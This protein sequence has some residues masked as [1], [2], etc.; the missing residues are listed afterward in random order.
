MANPQSR[1]RRVVR[2][3]VNGDHA[4]GDIL[5]QAPL[6]T[7]RRALPD[8]VGIEQQR[9]HHLRIERRAPPAISAIGLINSA[10]VDLL[11][12]VQHEPRQVVF[13]QPFTQTRRQQQLPLTI[14]R[15][16]VLGHQPP[17]TSGTDPILLNHPDAPETLCDSLVHAVFPSG[18]SCRIGSK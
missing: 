11:D 14:T 10:Q 4:E 15:N 2:S 1:D 7:T 17:P 9:D 8:R 16:E 6:D 13:R 12:R 5:T 3:L 18:D